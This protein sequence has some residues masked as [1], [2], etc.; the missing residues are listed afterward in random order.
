MSNIKKGLKIAE[1]IGFALYLGAS[2][3]AWVAFGWELAVILLLAVWG[4]N[5][6][7][8]ARRLAESIED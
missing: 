3:W 4:N 2:I 1:W 5:M 7:Q 8:V 6:Q